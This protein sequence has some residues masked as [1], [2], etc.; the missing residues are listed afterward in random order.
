MGDGVRRGPS[1]CCG[2]STPSPR[3]WGGW[4]DRWVAEG[5]Q[6]LAVRQFLFFLACLF[7][8][9]AFEAA[10]CGSRRG[11][12]VGSQ[13]RTPFSRGWLPTGTAEECAWVLFGLC[14]AGAR[15]HTD[16]ALS[17]DCLAIE[18]GV[19]LIRKVLS[20]PTAGP[21]RRRTPTAATLQPSH[22]TLRYAALLLSKSQMTHSNRLLTG[23]SA[24]TA[25]TSRRSA[26]P[27]TRTRART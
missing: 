10:S 5:G 15:A 21:A 9:F 23:A 4:T 8:L 14:L 2:G 7:V 19:K 12:A 17:T 25:C 27:C 6:W 24:C 11:D 13:G 18:V 20:L 26:P 16:T 22:Q 3:R 1:G